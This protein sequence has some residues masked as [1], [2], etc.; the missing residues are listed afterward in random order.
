MLFAT[1]AVAAQ[2]QA[3]RRGR[4]S[5]WA[6]YALSSAAM[7]W[8]QY[9]AFLPFL[10]QQLGF[11]V[12]W[13]SRRHRVGERRRLALGWLAATAAI[14]VICVPLLAFVRGQFV[15]YSNRSD[16]LVPGQ[17]GAGSS[18]LGGTISI[19]AVGA[20]VIWTVLGYH[21][22]GAMEQIAA[23]WPLVMLLVLLLLGRGRSGPSLL[24]LAL[25][26]LPMAAL[27]AIGSVKRDLF[28]LRYFS[29]AV[30]AALLLLARLVTATTR[31]RAALLTVSAVVVVTMAAG[32]L[33]QQQN[34]ANPR[35]YDFQGALA[36]VQ[37]DAGTRDVLLYEPSYLAD[38][39]QYYA[40][41]LRAV[42]LGTPVPPDATTVWVLATDRVVN[43]TDTAAKVGGVLADLEQQRQLVDTFERP[44]VKVWELR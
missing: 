44:N 12:A 5:D 7:L 36:E 40:P 37:D 15:A 27:F 26:V 34:G 30:P 14:V 25:V 29:G 32:L 38:V 1:L 31:R 22:D 19:Y 43:S 16:A 11:V 2:V 17:A 9:F 21:S 42:P 23:L 8:T 3:V 35:L 39:I 13:W 20:N 41:D 33:D 4:R 18:T 28:E 6:I 10:A 24:L